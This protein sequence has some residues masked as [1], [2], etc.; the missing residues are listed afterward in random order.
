[1][2]LAFERAPVEAP[3]VEQLMTRRLLPETTLR[4]HAVSNPLCSRATR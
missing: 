3:A 4:L 2:S 1:V